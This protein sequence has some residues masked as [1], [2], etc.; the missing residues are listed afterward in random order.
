MSE[1][2]TVFVQI[3]RPGKINPKGR[4]AEGRYI[5]ADGMVTLTDRDG[6]PVRDDRGKMY[7]YKLKD[8]DNPHA[9]AGRLTKEFRLALRGEKPSTGFSSPINY[10][11]TKVV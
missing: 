9:I 8:G 11:N 1:V 10:P 5:E 4:V 7:S 6:K 3:E 2:K